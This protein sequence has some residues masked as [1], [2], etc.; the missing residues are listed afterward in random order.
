M[1]NRSIRIKGL[2][3]MLLL[4]LATYAQ[5]AGATVDHNNFWENAFGSIVLLAGAIV[6]LAALMAIVRLFS[7]IVKMEE[8]RV[9]KEKGVEEI[10]EQYK[11]P[12]ESWWKKFM[13]SA[14]QY[15]PVEKEEDIMFDHEYD[16]IRELDNRLPPWWL[17]MFYASII[18][19]AVY[20][21]VY[22][23]ADGPSLI[24]EY[25]K[26]MEV[27]QA[28]IDEYM[29]TK[30][31]AIDENTVSL[32]T[33]EESLSM[34]Q[35]TFETLCMPCHGMHG[36]G[37]AI[38]PNLTDDYW[39]HGCGIKNVFHTISNGVIEKGMQAWKE[40]LRPVEIQRVASYVVYKLHGSNPENA[41]APQGELC[42]PQESGDTEAAPDKAPTE[43]ATE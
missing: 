18:F 21:T 31:D 11:Q 39:L 20:W 10:A 9:L 40:Q 4:P 27:A 41:K 38:G 12:Q 42:K 14:T 13:K 30:A 8:L 5:D 1:K 16:G 34:G 29:A 36:E 28:K 15:V 43:E 32:L 7:V 6:V 35:S 2:L 24:D 23:I 25:N 19:A 22:H 3:A 17:W 37:N 26:E 33:D